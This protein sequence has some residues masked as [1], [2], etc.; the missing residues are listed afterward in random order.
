MTLF[1]RIK[2]RIVESAPAL[3]V[4]EI[5]PPLEVEIGDY[6]SLLRGRVLN[7]G[8]GNRDLSALVDG[9]LTNQDIP[10]GLHNANIHI[11]SPLHDIPRPDGYFD[12]VFCNAVLEHVANPEDVMC[13]FARICR[14]GGAL[15]L[16]VPFMQPEHKDPT[17]FQR[18][19][20]DGLAAL[21]RRHGFD[22]RA[23]EAVHNIYTTF[24]WLIIA[25]LS[26]RRCVRNALLR[27]IFYPLLRRLCRRSNEQVFAAAST[28]RLIATRGNPSLEAAVMQA[29]REVAPG[30]GGP[31]DPATPLGSEGVGLDSVGFLELVL[32]VEK[33]SGVHLRDA[34]LTATALASP[35][36]L[37][38]H[39]EE[40]KRATH[41]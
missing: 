19:T 13:E 25:W 18:Y 30:Y 40:C 3:E 20:A 23:I 41:D 11:Y 17:D 6:R 29:V 12:V 31:L 36:S 33:C 34:S 38:R 22:V 37:V 9:E 26:H 28:Y 8:A 7:A 1:Q 4:S 27:W 15:Y 16:C 5:F 24:A 10:Q 21:A 39:L 2:R 14:P 32:A 35:G